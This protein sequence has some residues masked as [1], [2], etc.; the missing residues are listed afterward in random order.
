MTFGRPPAIPDNYVQL[1]LPIVPSIS[2]GQPVVDDETIRQSVY[3]FNHTMLV[4]T[5]PSPFDCRR[6]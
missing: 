4:D 5:T 6:N 2:E 3:F 1:D